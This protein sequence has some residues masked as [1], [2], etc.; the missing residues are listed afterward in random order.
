VRRD[1]PSRFAARALERARHRKRRQRAAAPPRPLAEH[2]PA[3]AF[4][5]L[6]DALVVTFPHKDER[7]WGIPT[8]A[9][10]HIAVI[11]FAILAPI[12]W[13]PPP[14]P[15]NVVRTFF[16][17]APPPPPLQRRGSPIVLKRP[18]DDPAERQPDLL[19]EKEETTFKTEKVPLQIPE[20]ILNPNVDIQYGVEDGF[21]LGELEGME[22]GVP[23]GV[24]GGVPG[25][26]VGGVIG[27]TGTEVYLRPDVPPR[28][29]RMP[30]PSYTVEAIR[31]K[32]TGNV[33]LRAI[34][35]VKGRVK[36]L[37]VIRS[38]PELDAEAIRVVETEWVFRPALKNNRP[39]PSLAELT[40]E[41]N[42]F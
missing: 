19:E 12:L 16:D 7:R 18:Y 5:L 13:P 2:P 34:I 27:G 11:G 20:E 9:A 38:I 35:D 26:I 29:I 23:G 4:E 24:V 21:D 36:V 3:A 37:R 1:Q 10:I 41:F 15:P 8:A 31:K 30:Q 28:P 39:V 25:G 22:G 42:L 6:S 40:V 33:I 14:P 17:S 32:V